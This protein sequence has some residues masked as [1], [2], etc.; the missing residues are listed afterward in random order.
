MNIKNICLE[1]LFNGKS[2]V[3]DKLYEVKPPAASA[4]KIIMGLCVSQQGGSGNVCRDGS[5]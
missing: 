1:F 3:R 4:K 2:F 5:G